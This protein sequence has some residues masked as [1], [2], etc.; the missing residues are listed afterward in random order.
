M[1]GKDNWTVIT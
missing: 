1:G